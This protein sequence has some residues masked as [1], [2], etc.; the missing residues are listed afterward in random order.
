[1]IIHYR[2]QTL[3]GF[4][5]RH[6]YGKDGNCVPTTKTDTERQETKDTESGNP[7]S[8]FTQSERQFK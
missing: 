6:G 4:T 2:W 8:I 5:L 7:Q 1:M 3:F